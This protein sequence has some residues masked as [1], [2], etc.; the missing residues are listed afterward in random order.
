MV[1]SLPKCKKYIKSGPLNYNFVQAQY[2]IYKLMMGKKA[3]I[4]FIDL[5]SLIIGL[6]LS[7]LLKKMITFL[8]Y[9][10][11]NNVNSLC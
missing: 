3:L 9:N 5:E 2:F 7:A 10:R 1:F 6:S 8:Y 11:Y 4:R